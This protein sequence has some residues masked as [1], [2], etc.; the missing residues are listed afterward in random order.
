MT[1]YREIL[2]LHSLGVNNSQIRETL[3]CSRQTVVTTLQKAAEQHLSWPVPD[4]LTNEALGKLFYPSQKAEVVYAMP[5]CEWVY[6]E[7][8]KPGVTLSLLWYEYHEKCVREGTIPY[9]IT[10]FKKYCHDYAVKQQ[11]THASGAQTR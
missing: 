8:K 4:N 11:L 7:L 6:Q 10:Q 9:K 5:D 2:R 1:N 3:Q